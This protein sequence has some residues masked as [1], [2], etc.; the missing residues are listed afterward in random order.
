MPQTHLTTHVS[1]QEEV[2]TAVPCHP[3][4]RSSTSGTQRQQRIG[5]NAQLLQGHNGNRSQDR[6]VDTGQ[7][8]SY[9]MSVEAHRGGL[10]NDIRH[11]N[12][13]QEQQQQQQHQMIART[14]P[15]TAGG[16]PSTTKN[17]HSGC[18]ITI[19]NA[20]GAKEQRQ[21]RQHPSTPNIATARAAPIIAIG[22]WD[23]CISKN[24]ATAPV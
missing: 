6:S 4:T 11:A 23:P 9:F 5:E 14:T 15:E 22:V 10:T 19:A 21:Q 24:M 20:K 12:D 2:P 16:T 1:R 13:I 17:A 18:A 7:H 8:Q 3:I